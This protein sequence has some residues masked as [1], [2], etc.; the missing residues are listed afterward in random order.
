M[1]QPGGDEGVDELF[2]IQE[3]EAG[4]ESSNISKVEEG[5]FAKVVGES[6]VHPITLTPKPVAD[7]DRG[8]FWP[9][10][11]ILVMADLI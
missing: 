7:I 2:C 8:T 5:C 9:E 1:V 10:K 6:G 3:G 4:A 11:V